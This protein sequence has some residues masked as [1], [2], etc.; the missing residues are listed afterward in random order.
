MIFCSQEFFVEHLAQEIYENTGKSND[1]TY[2]S[3][4]DIVQKSDSMEFLKGK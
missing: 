4:A 3:L 1:V 2:H